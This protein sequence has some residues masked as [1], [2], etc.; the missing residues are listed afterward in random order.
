M[1]SDTGT[2]SRSFLTESV[3]KSIARLPFIWQKAVT[4]FTGPEGGAVKLLGT[5]KSIK[6]KYSGSFLQHHL[7]HDCSYSLW[8]G[9]SL[10]MM[11]LV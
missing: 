7:H 2:E 6:I 8:T 10:L 11:M 1:G 4:K 9:V 3:K 5:I